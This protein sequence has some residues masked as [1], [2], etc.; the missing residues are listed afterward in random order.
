MPK[1]KNLLV[2]ALK[3][4][5]SFSIIAYL[6][7][8]IAPVKDIL[9]VLRGIDIFWLILS[10]SLHSLGFLFSAIRW[11]I[12]IRAQGDSVPLGLLIQSYLVAGFFNNFLPTRFGGD[13][14]RIWD[15]TRYSRSLLKSSAIV[16]V[17][18]F[19][20]IIVLLFF[21]SVASLFRLDMAQRIPVIWVSLLIGLFGLLLIMI[22]FT[23]LARRALEKI[24]EKK[25]LGKGKKK[26]IEF[27]EIVLIYKDK[28]VFLLKAFF[29]AFLLQVNV[30]VHYYFLGKALH[31]NIN[32]LDYFM[33]VPI[34]LLILAVPIT[35]SGLGL[36]E[37]SY[38]EI[39]RF[40][41]VPP[42]TAISFGLIDWAFG[43]IVGIAGGII[44]T[45]RK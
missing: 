7:I 8:K 36:R 12:L 30:I 26:L 17:D 38:M 1:I 24:P 34:V 13:I 14:V 44:Y 4:V 43:L 41:G 42:E 45:V 21:A 18:R 20:G 2:F 33:F 3:F 23:P 19:T 15:G 29:W 11:Q 40:Y 25:F 6:L 27:R 31:I 9:N 37:G 22:F 39:F 10:F 28:K 16:L 35:I 32:L 5:F